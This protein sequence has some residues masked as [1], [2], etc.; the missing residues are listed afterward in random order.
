M[1]LTIKMVIFAD[2][3]DFQDRAISLSA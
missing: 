3:A 2:F 1:I